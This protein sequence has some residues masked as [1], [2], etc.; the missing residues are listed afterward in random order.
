MNVIIFLLSVSL[1][2]A[3]SF[4]G[5]YIWS[6]KTGQFDDDYSPAH[7]IFFEDNIKNENKK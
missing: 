5:A 1:V 2:V 6:V 7:R 3:L 4:L